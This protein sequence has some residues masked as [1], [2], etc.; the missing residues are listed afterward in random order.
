MKLL[1]VHNCYGKRSGEEVMLKRIIDLLRSR[2]HAVDTYF[3][4]SSTIRGIGG[5][6]AAAA[7]GIRS[8]SSMSALRAQLTSSRPDL[9]QVQNLYPLISPA[10]LP[11][12]REAGVPIVMRLSNYRLVCP[13]GLFLS[14]GMICEA[15]S[16]GREWNCIMK[17]C[18]NSIFKSTAYAARNAWARKRGY[19]QDNVTRY[20]AQTAFQR[21]I[22]VREGYPP[23]R[24]DVIPNMIDIPESEPV[25]T[26]GTYVG[27]VGRLSAEK[28]ID[29]LLDAAR[30]LPKVP[31]RLAGDHGLWEGRNDLPTNLTLLGRLDGEALA[32]FYRE[33]A[34]IVVPSLWYEGFPGVIT[35]AMRYARPVIVSGIGG[36]T[37][38][39]EP[40]RTGLV[41]PP[42]VPESLAASIE[43]LWCDPVRRCAMGKAGFH[44][45]KTYYSGDH[46]YRNL[47]ETYLKALG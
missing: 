8:M 45:A 43:A 15:C 16:G 12:I 40:D 47:V 7:S 6:L 28:G 13:S 34:L 46:Y 36:L 14:Q 35:E 42:G 39:I 21:S 10:V 20:Y 22:L 30:R 4:D 1:F 37:E 23:D 31:F 32:A 44:R 18:E 27:F 17:N 9:V 3:A 26:D 41:T 19:Y 11:V 24:I 33:A 38:I 5:K 25:W 2:G 29:T